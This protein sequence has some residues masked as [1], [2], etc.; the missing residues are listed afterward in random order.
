MLR[1]VSQKLSRRSSTESDEAGGAQSQDVSVTMVRRR[2]SLL[3]RLEQTRWGR[4]RQ[5]QKLGAIANIL[6][7]LK[8]RPPSAA[9]K[10]SG[11]K[12]HLSVAEMKQVFASGSDVQMSDLRFGS[13]IAEGAFATVSRGMLHG[14]K[15]AIKQLKLE[16]AKSNAAI[17]KELQHEVSI[18]SAMRHPGLLSLIGSTNDPKQPCIILEFLEGTIYDALGGLLFTESVTEL[19]LL[20]MLRDTVAALAYLHTRP[21]PILHRDLKPPNVLCD[22]R[23]HCK[24]ADFGT[25]CALSTPAARVND[26]IG[27]ALY[28][29]PEVERG[30]SYSLPSDVFS[31]GAM[32]YELYYMLDNSGESFYEDMQLFTGMEVMRTPLTSTPQE[33]PERPSSCGDKMWELLTSTV[34]EAEAQRPTFVTIASTLLEVEDELSQGSLTRWLKGL[35]A[36]KT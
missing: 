21:S 20:P 10:A 23:R 32:L 35:P 17:L 29:A 2:S 13:A 14:Q 12:R 6:S 30:D 18:M 28:M 9:E 36:G 7:H 34:Q 33:M 11:I 26:C 24:L 27:T 4:V 3:R 31:F 5:A 1:R 15:V 22:S 25:A 19:T 16:D 8:D